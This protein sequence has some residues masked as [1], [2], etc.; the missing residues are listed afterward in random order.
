MSPA[1][2]DVLAIGNAIVDV[3]SRVDETFLA[4]HSIT[5]GA[6]QLIDETQARALY[7]KMGAAIEMSGGSAANTIAGAAQLGTRTA[8]I[9]KVRND[10]LGEVFM[11]DI[12]ASGVTFNT[13]PASDG[14]ATARC[15]VLVTPDGERSMNTFLG[16]SVGLEPRDIDARL[17]A[18]AG[19]VYLEGYLWDPPQ[20]KEAFVRAAN[21]ARGAGRQVALT[22]SDAFCVDRHRDSF[23]E[24]IK[25]D[26]DIL[27]ANEAEIKSLYQADGFDDAL[28][29]VRHDCRLAALT[30]SGAGSVIVAG[31]EIHVVEARKVAKVADS[32][33]AG[34]L[35]AA[36]FLHG[37]TTHKD[38]ATC[39][40][41]GALAAAEII[42]HVGARPETSLKQLAAEAGLL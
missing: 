12:R 39:A 18:D 36:G 14:P 27:F 32:T 9:G 11:H 3:I 25:R 40:R 22:L 20:A 23:L 4:S 31:D 17:I 2:Y 26:V 33:G 6:M 7:G 21:I 41:L 29:H 19:I 5:K 35:Y 30:R 42:S 16:A 28:Q 1:Q 38:L 34:D 24:L 15:L 10:Q 8:F 37:L 13:A